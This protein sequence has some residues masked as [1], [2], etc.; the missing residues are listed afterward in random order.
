M[1]VSKTTYCKSGF[2]GTDVILGQ[3]TICMFGTDFILGQCVILYL[4]EIVTSI[5]GTDLILGQSDICPNCP[6][7]TAVP[8]KPLL[9]YSNNIDQLSAIAE[10]QMQTVRDTAA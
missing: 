9:Q 5:F 1:Y 10:F 3:P 2:I 7:I 6:K 8:I 4:Q